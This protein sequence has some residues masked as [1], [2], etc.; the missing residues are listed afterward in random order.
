MALTQEEE[1]YIKEKKKKDDAEKQ[2]M[3]LHNQ[4][5][6][7]LEAKRLEMKAIQDKLTQDVTAVKETLK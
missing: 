7:D 5:N 1:T 3:A 2:I 6:I 4:A